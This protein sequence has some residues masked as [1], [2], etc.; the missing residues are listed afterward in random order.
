[1]K[2]I[3]DV[4]ENIKPKKRNSKIDM[5]SPWTPPHPTKELTHFRIILTN[6]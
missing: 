4:T 2:G 3:V 5:E 6:K 1:M